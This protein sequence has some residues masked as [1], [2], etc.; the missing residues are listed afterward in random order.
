MSYYCYS[1]EQSFS[2]PR[3]IKSYLCK[4][5]TCPL[6]GETDITEAHFCETDICTNLIPMDEKLCKAC[7]CELL[8]KFNA[9]ADAL[10]AVEEEALDDMLDGECIADRKKWEEKYT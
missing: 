4:E 10:T 7:R 6:C 3:V 1:C 8:R 2:E 9:F 5:Y